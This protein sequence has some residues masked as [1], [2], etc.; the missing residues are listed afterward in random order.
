MNV[1][2]TD[3]FLADIQRQYEWYATNAGWEL[4]DRYL[5]AV[6][7]VC[8]L[9]SQQP[10]LGPLSRFAHPRLRTWRFFLVL[11]PFSR[12]IVFYEIVD[13]EVILRRTMHGQRDLPRR[14]IEMDPEA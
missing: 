1:R 10:T 4:A 8:R 9:L 12:H 2:K 7:A 14:L 11:R 6:E 5:D 3:A 13:S